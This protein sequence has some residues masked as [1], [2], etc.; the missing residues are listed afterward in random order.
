MQFGGEPG[1]LSQELKFCRFPPM[2]LGENNEGE[3]R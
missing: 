1:A 3:D 2:R